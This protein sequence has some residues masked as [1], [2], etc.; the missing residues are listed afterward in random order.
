MAIVESY[1][2]V[3]GIYGGELTKEIVRN[4]T[5]AFSKRKK[6]IVVGRDTRK[7]SKE[8]RHLIVNSAGIE[9]IDV[10]VASTPEIQLAVRLFGAD[11]GIIITASHNEPEY[12]GMKF[13]GK[14]GAII[15]KNE[16]EGLIKAAKVTGFPKKSKVVEKGISGEYVSF[17][18]DIVGA[19]DRIRKKKFSVVIDPNGG[20]GIIAKKV[21]ESA[22]VNVTVINGKPGAFRRKIEPTES[23]LK[24]LQRI[25]KNKKADLG[26]GFD[27]D[28]DRAEMVL[29]NRFVSGH[30]VLALLVMAAARNG[31]TVVINDA[32]SNVVREVAGKLGCGVLEAEVGEVNVI[33]KMEAAKAA[34][35]GEGS[36]GGG[37]LF[38][39]R[40]RDGT[41]TLMMIL[42]LMAENG[43][44]L[45]E[46]LGEMPKYY[47]V[48]A[49]TSISSFN[50]GAFESLLK[51]KYGK[52]ASHGDSLKVVFK[53][54]FLWFRAS[55]TESGII[56]V[57]ADARSE[58]RAK[59]LIMEGLF[60]LQSFK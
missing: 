22:G 24:N 18:R 48:Q 10:G 9:V 34:V 6:K 5:V 39:S 58:N 12:N 49:K 25:V 59:V 53:D 41:L 46:I 21:L 28:A 15:G 7:S 8:M 44:G 40:C 47:T 32:T 16:M 1:S 3:R 27:C 45:Q 50:N 52:V 14:N 20:T 11:G 38:P 57:I 35:G 2:G 37:I 55:R 42:K 17:V 23:S 4:Y 13:L 60:L 31:D 36:S 56:R 29:G 30:Y 33:S 54:S 43:K 19:F 51:R 26:V